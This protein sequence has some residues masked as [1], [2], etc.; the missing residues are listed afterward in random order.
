MGANRPSDTF[1]DM[2]YRASKAD[3]LVGT[4]WTRID[5]EKPIQTDDDTSIFR[6]Y[7]YLVG[8]VDGTSDEFTQFQLKIVLRSTNQTKVP[9]LNDLRV[10]ALGD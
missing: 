7:R 4:T 5:S 2:Y 10:I 1:I 6:E 9:K 3:T 8:A